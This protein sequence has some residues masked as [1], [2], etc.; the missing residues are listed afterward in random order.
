[1]SEPSHAGAAAKK[2]PRTVTVHVNEKPVEVPAGSAT[3]LQIKELAI[4]QGVAIQLDFVLVEELAH[5]RTKVIGNDDV[6]KVTG[7]TRFLANDGDDNS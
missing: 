4:K 1:M 6:V 5:D 7:K 2:P 3:G